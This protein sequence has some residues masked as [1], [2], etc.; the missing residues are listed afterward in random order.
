MWST[1]EEPLP[2]PLDDRGQ[3][4]WLEEDDAAYDDQEVTSDDNIY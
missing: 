1:G 3:H 2:E 4:P